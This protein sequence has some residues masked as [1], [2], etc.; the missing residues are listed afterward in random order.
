MNYWFKCRRYGLARTKGL[1]RTV[2]NQ[3]CRD[4]LCRDGRLSGARG[5]DMI[6][7]KSTDSSPSTRFQIVQISCR[8]PS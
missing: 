2:I 1:A 5:V 6:L 3:L 7:E 8:D 4:S